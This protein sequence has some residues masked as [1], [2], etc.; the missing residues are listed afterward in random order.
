MLSAR[1]PAYLF[2]TIDAVPR[3]LRNL[4]THSPSPTEAIISTGPSPIPRQSVP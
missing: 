4:G 3:T 1:S 2:H